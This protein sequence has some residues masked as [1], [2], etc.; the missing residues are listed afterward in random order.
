MISK[1][2]QIRPETPD[3]FDTI[4]ALTTA[5]FADMPYSD[6][7]EAECIKRLR[8][9]GDLTLSLVAIENGKIVGHAAFSPVT[10]SDGSSGW[11]GLGPISVWP[12]QQKTG[13]GSRLINEGLKQIQQNGAPGCVLVGDPNYYSK[14]GFVADGRIS[15]RDLPSE[16][17]QWI[18]FGD[19]KP[20][21]VVIYSSGLE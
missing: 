18:A 2:M 8:S 7:S 12:D 6:G 1:D 16:Y 5:A 10:L 15:Y 11:M 17:V 14:F 4:D 19:E 20:S 9:D 3:D 13:V 21:G